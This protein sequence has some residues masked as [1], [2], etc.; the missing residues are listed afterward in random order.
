MRIIAIAGNTF[1]E[2]LR[3]KVLLALIVIAVLVTAAAKIVPP[4]AVGEGAKIVKDLGLAT[5]TLFCVL[6]AIL[7]GGRLIYKEVEKRT[8]LTLLAKPVRRWEFVLGKYC[9]LMLVLI[10]SV[11]LMT[12]WF[13]LFLL[14]THVPLDIRL[15]LPIAMLVLELGIVTA[16]SIL[17]STFT[18][19]ISSTV[20]AFATYFAGNMSRDLLAL[21]AMNKSLL[22][23]ALARFCYY[24]LP[25]FS[26]LD[27]RALVIHNQLLDPGQ[28]LW[29]IAY[30]A[31]YTTAL[32]LIAILIFQRRNF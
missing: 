25:N 22:V 27:F 18:T 4:L 5:M 6:I 11:A 30:S 2:A 20:F 16:V 32:L 9:G 13:T 7:V 8:I 28:V 15:L 24:L 17:F 10:I 14:L 26:N 1:R 19:P 31:I 12:L 3:D 23:K 29:A 21:A